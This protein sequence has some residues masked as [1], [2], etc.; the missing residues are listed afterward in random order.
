MNKCSSSFPKSKSAFFNSQQNVC[1]LCKDNSYSIYQCSIFKGYSV[2]ERYE[3]VKKN[4]L[5]INCLHPNHT[6][7]S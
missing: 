5:C 6:I 2:L 3:L 4:K 1:V 7:T